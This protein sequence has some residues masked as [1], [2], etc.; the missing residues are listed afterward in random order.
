MVYC[1]RR[2]INLLLVVICWYLLLPL[3]AQAGEDTWTA[4]NLQGYNLRSIAIDPQQ[5][6]RL[7]AFAREATFV[8]NDGGS[9]WAPVSLPLQAPPEP[10]QFQIDPLTPNIMYATSYGLLHRS[11]DGG[12]SWGQLGPGLLEDVRWF[13]LDRTSPNVIW[14]FTGQDTLRSPDGGRTWASAGLPARGLATAFAQAADGSTTYLV[15]ER[16]GLYRSNDGG[17]TWQALSSNDSAAPGLYINGLALDRADADTVFVSNDSGTL[18]SSDRGAT[19]QPVALP[20]GDWRRAAL[21]TTASGLL[22]LQANRSAISNNG[23]ATWQVSQET[24]YGNQPRQIAVDPQVAS[25]VYLLTDSGVWK[26]QDGGA[27]WAGAAAQPANLQ[28]LASH[29]SQTNVLV[30]N[31]NAGLHRS[32]DGGLTWQPAPGLVEGRNMSAFAWSPVDPQVAYASYGQGLLRSQDG[33]QTWDETLLPGATS[34]QALRLSPTDPNLLYV[35]SDGRVLVSGDGGNAW[36]V[37]ALPPDV[38]VTDLALSVQD[39][40]VLA[41]ASEHAIYLSSDGGQSWSTQVDDL[42]TIGQL[43]VDPVDQQHLLALVNGAPLVSHDSGENW[44]ASA[45]P[46]DNGR[47]QAIMIDARNPSLAVAHDGQRFYASLSAGDAWYAV[48]EAAPGGIAQIVL[49]GDEPRTLLAR[50]GGGALWR[51]SFR[52]APATPSPTP[53]QTPTVTPTPTRTPTPA[54]TATPVPTR[55]PTPTP[56]LQVAMRPAATPVTLD[57]PQRATSSSGGVGLPVVVGVLALIGVAVAVFIWL[58]RAPGKMVA[59]EPPAP[60][61]SQGLV[62]SQGHTSPPNSKFCMTCGEQLT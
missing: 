7:Y 51:Y 15:V 2:V 34:V 59:T 11:L 14:V 38:H 9:Q 25:V 6:A 57:P 39:A 21:A 56:R 27:N 44:Q 17:K 1:K 3:T 60:P 23:G 61:T 37:L 52:G 20:E 16:Q 29:P 49:V 58:R 47:L 13:Q 12:A 45:G 55:T 36:G 53:T 10:G 35:L 54:P 5:P 19:W 62:C 32:G 31:S 28:L 42:W 8:S 43:L 41:A 26:S 40:D 22:L 46:L 48:A 24:G 18:R 50:S 30:A 33:G 4:D